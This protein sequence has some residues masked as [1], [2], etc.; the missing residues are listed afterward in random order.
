MIFNMPYFLS[1]TFK[2]LNNL[3]FIHIINI[4]IFE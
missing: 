2:N 1:D 3:K 4:H